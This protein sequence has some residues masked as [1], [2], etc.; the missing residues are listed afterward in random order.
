MKFKNETN[1]YV[2]SLKTDVDESKIMRAF[3]KYGKVTS[4]CIKVHEP[5][6]TTGTATPADKQLVKL[7]FG[8]INFNTAEEAKNA[9]TECKKDPAVLSCIDQNLNTRG[10][11]FIYYA[12]TKT[13]RQQYLR[14]QKKNL[15]TFK[16]IQDNVLQYY[17]LMKYFM[18][19]NFRNNQRNPRAPNNKGPKGQFNQYNK[20]PYQTR[21]HY[22]G[23]RDQ[24]MNQQQHPFGN[25]NQ[26]MGGVGQMNTP[27][28]NQ[29]GQTTAPQG[30]T[31]APNMVF[32]DMNFNMPAMNN[33]QTMQAFQAQM[34]NQN[35]NNQGMVGMPQSMNMMQNTAPMAA[36]VK[37]LDWLKNNLGIFEKLDQHEKKNILGNL[38]YPLV[39]SNVTNPE[40]VPK[41]TG[42]LI[43]LEVLKANEIVEIMENQDALKDRI[44]E[45]IG[46][47]NDTE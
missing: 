37:D 10:T 3:E 18:P 13:V 42:M 21:G 24:H 11:E 36:P 5:K 28:P 4:V 44:D 33:M 9:F 39:E 32:N 6:N 35:M 34:M 12:Q 20:K 23:Q 17:Q 40:H 38:M 31:P 1:L 45:A 15:K 41:I 43:D 46:I 2:K 14:M 30:Q 26:M 22:T 47:I 25:M 8:F 19:Q 16:L 29:Q 7:R 27:A